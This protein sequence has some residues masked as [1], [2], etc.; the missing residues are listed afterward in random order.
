[1]SEEL[2]V[3]NEKSFEWAI[4]AGTHATQEMKPGQRLTK[5]FTLD[6]IDWVVSF[7]PHGNKQGQQKNSAIY[8][9]YRRHRLDVLPTLYTFDYS[10]RMTGHRYFWS[11]PPGIPTQFNRGKV[12]GFRNFVP[13]DELTSCVTPEDTLIIAVTLLKK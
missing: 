7:Y 10:L 4:K 1:M 11:N 5:S 2:K 3:A 12:V 9:N 13:R 6:N 8:L